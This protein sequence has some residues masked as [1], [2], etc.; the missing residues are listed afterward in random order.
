MNNWVLGFAGGDD[1]VGELVMN[2]CNRGCKPCKLV[3]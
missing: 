3:T 2:V 1:I